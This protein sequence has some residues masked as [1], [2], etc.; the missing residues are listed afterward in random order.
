MSSPFALITGDVLHLE[1][2]EDWRDACL[3]SP[4]ERWADGGE[5]SAKAH[6]PESEPTGDRLG[7]G[8][9]LDALLCTPSTVG[10]MDEGLVGPGDG[11]TTTT[12]TPPTHASLRTVDLKNVHFDLDAVGEDDPSD[13]AMLEAKLGRLERQ[14]RERHA[15]ASSAPGVNQRTPF[16]LLTGDVS[17]LVV[18]PPTPSRPR[19]TTTGGNQRTP[20]LRDTA[21]ALHRWLDETVLDEAVR[22]HRNALAA[23]PKTS[24]PPTPP[25]P[26]FGRRPRSPPRPPLD[27][28]GYSD[29]LSGAPGKNQ[30]KGQRS[31]PRS[32]RCTV[33]ASPPPAPAKYPS[34]SATWHC[35]APPDPA[36]PRTAEPPLEYSGA[37]PLRRVHTW[38]SLV[39][40]VHSLLGCQPGVRGLAQ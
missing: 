35:P 3:P 23:G 32:P 27:S 29:R 30:R 34:F 37:T 12:A 31:P 40:N 17:L 36:A 7:L 9:D 8:L 19:D 14:E 11:S 39:Q 1:R 6:S 2:R 28:A 16:A 4:R 22:D 24:R 5:G 13:E 10:V 26:V 33:A 18:E 15:A 25:T 38:S 21:S 20:V